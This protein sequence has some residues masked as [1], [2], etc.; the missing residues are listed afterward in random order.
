MS[1]MRSFRNDDPWGTSP[2]TG[3]AV[4]AG[5]GFSFQRE[6]PENTQQPVLGTLEA[7]V[8]AEGPVDQKRRNQ[9]K[10]QECPSV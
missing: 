6:N 4:Q 5:R 9:K 7:E 3:A 2:V 1:D 8:P 10:G